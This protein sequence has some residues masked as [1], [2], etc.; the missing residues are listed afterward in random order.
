LRLWAIQ[1]GQIGKFNEISSHAH[2]AMNVKLQWPATL[3]WLGGDNFSWIFFLHSC[4]IEVQLLEDFP[5]G[6]DIKS[7]CWR[8]RRLN[9]CDSCHNLI[10]RSQRKS[11]GFLAQDIKLIKE[12]KENCQ[13]WKPTLNLAL[14]CLLS[15]S[16]FST[17]PPDRWMIRTSSPAGG[18]TSSSPRNTDR[19]RSP[20][21]T[22]CPTPSRIC[23]RALTTRQ[24]CRPRIAMAGTRWVLYPIALGAKRPA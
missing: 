1:T 16:F 22:S 13:W 14:L 9:W 5:L 15:L 10:G 18:T 3:R 17:F 23:I 12:S 8:Q 4:A 11:F 19:P 21:H 6:R 2:L 7:L 20:W 24:L